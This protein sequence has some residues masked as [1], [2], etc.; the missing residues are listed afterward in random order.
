MPDK[1]LTPQQY[2]PNC[3]K[4]TKHNVRYTKYLCDSCMR[5]VCDAKGRKVVF[6]NTDAFGGCQGYYADT[7]LKELYNSNYCYIQ[8]QKYKASEARFGGIV[9]I[10]VE[11]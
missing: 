3:K 10:P 11:S 1:E 5:L 2:C 6:Y 7:Q 9:I 4:E 8:E